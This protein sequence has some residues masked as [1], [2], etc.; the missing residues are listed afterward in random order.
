MANAEEMRDTVEGVVKKV[1]SEEVGGKIEEINKDTPLPNTPEGF[2]VAMRMANAIPMGGNIIL[3]PPNVTTIGGIVDQ[4]IE[5]MNKNLEKL[6][7]KT[8]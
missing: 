6:K 3:N 4:C 5:E 1:F 7:Q 2:S 8:D